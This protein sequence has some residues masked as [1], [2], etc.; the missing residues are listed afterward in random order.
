MARN[1][2][3]YDRKANELDAVRV[4][5]EEEL[6][7]ELA[8]LDE[9]IR[10]ARDANLGR[11]LDSDLLADVREALLLP[12]ASWNA[13]PPRPGV[14]ARIRAWFGRLLAWFRGLFGRGSKKRPVPRTGRT[15]P[16]ATLGLVGRR[17]DPSLLGD[18]LAQLSSPQQ[19]ELREKVEGRIERQES[20]LRKEAEAKRRDA[21][22]QRRALNAEKEEIRRRAQRDEAGWIRDAERRRVDRE[23]EERGLVVPH[24]EGLAVTYALVERFARLLLEEENRT[25]SA[26]VRLSLKGGGSTGVYEKARLRVPEEIAHLDISSSL[27]ASRLAGLRHIDE[28]TSLVYREVTSERA[29][30]VLALDKSGSMAEGEKL[31][32][33][34]KALLALYSAVRRKYPDAQVDVIAFDNEVRVLD[35]LQLWECPPGSFTNTGEALRTAFY[36][37]RNSRATRRELFL[38]TDGLPESYTDADGTVKSGNLDVA[39]A[40]ALA[41]AHELAA[42]QP[43][44]FTLLLLKSEHPEYEKAARLLTR[45]LRGELIVTEPRR[46]AFEMLVRWAGGA[47]VTRAPRGTT[48][49][50]REVAPIPASPPSGPRR[51]KADRRMGG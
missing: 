33:A 39:L 42:V 34:K 51:R 13:P 27:V 47:E 11:L 19:Q 37:L 24:G 32:A 10:R 41:R 18:A 9:R 15:I 44:R 8:R 17:L 3:E 28:R 5:S 21:E 48:S 40:N 14:W 49:G 36:L 29:H 20:E 35:L 31:P 22:A 43:L 25:L 26:S 23:L 38:L 1:L 12:D 7:A 16:I 4:R 2:D 30:V 50:E 46:L 45:A 6:R